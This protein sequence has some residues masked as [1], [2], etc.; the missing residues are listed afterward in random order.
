MKGSGDVKDTTTLTNFPKKKTTVE[1]SLIDVEFS[2]TRNVFLNIV[3]V[4]SKL[5]KTTEF[6]K[7]S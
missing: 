2:S 7:V 5:N 6:R 3:V 1:I 4:M